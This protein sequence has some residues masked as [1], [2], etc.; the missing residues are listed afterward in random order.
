M[1]EALSLRS[2]LRDSGASNCM[3]IYIITGKFKLKPRMS[4]QAGLPEKM[5]LFPFV[6]IRTYTNLWY[7]KPSHA[8]LGKSTNITCT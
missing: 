7:I 1:L 8:S 4:R 5:D 2:W 6:I 3:P